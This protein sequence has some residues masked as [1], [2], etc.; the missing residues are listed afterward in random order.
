MIPALD[1][2]GRRRFL[3]NLPSST[4]VEKARQKRTIVHRLNR[5]GGALAVS[6]GESVYLPIFEPNT[7][8][9]DPD[10]D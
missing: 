4:A 9:K 10:P 3:G 7:P 5:L 2:R 6:G 1:G 8:D